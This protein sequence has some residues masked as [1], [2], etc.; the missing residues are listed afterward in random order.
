MAD[1]CT[2]GTGFPNAAS[3]QQMATNYPIIWEEICQLQQAILAASSQCQ[4]G[5]GKMS[6]TVAGTT[7]M[8][9]IAGVSSITINDGG[10]GY[11]VDMP[12]V[13]FIPPLGSPTG[14]GASADV[15][16]NG[17]NIIQ[18]SIT[19]GGSGYQPVP[20]TMNVSSLAGLGAIINP[21]VNA[22]GSIIG[23]DIVNGGSGYTLLDSVTASR[24]VAPNPYYY[25]AQF[26]ITEV[27]VT[28]EIISIAILLPG[29]GYQPSVTTVNIISSLNPLLT[30]PLGSGFNGTVF[31][32]SLGTI[33]QVSI[34]NTGA[35]Y[36]E[37]PPYL[38]ISDP[39]T[40]AETSVNLIGNSVQSI[41]VLNGGDQYT[42]SA[43][44]TVYNP[45]T[46]ALPNPPASSA[47]VT[48]NVIENT[49][50]TDPVLYW[51]VWAGV[52]TN[53]PIQA[54]LNTVLSYFQG[55]G[56]TILIESN[57]L[58]NNTIQWKLGW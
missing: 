8:T 57:P 11:Y 25:D 23:V 3:M 15:I 20:S 7:P 9:F 58:T 29:T 43:T 24:A 27:S 32:D 48:I 30:Y 42:S 46:A 36:A 6:V 19:D 5:G 22:T 40:G 53:R 34:N 56:Y 35:G 44:G 33:T 39:G 47:E 10:A 49:Y 17:S 55:L 13:E 54:Q 12:S 21:L 37:F 52:T 28:G 38:V 45:P 16:T 51:Q 31:T 1:C 14:S 26:K 2:P 50:G 18:I 41:D 4:P